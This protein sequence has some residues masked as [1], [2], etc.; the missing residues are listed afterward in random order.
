M[1]TFLDGKFSKW[2]T[3]YTCDS[4]LV[5]S[6]ELKEKYTYIYTYIFVGGN[7]LTTNIFWLSFSK[8]RF[9]RYSYTLTKTLCNHHCNQCDRNLNLVLF[10]V[11]WNF[12]GPIFSSVPNMK[13]TTLNSAPN[14]LFY[15]WITITMSRS[16]NLRLHVR[17][18]L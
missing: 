18:L 3:I 9:A 17:P 4:H 11:R 10:D 7:W 1:K 12:Q 8:R 14:M 2:F 6:I 15:F 13:N 5:N 16:N